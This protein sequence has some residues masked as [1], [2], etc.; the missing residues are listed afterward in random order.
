MTTKEPAGQF[1][2]KRRSARAQS[3]PGPGDAR[4][5]ADLPQAVAGRSGDGQTSKTEAGNPGAAAAASSDEPDQVV[6][7]IERT[8]EQLGETVE[9]L[10]AK[11]D[12]AAMAKGKIGQASAHAAE[13]AS[14]ARQQAAVHAARVRAQLSDR[15]AGPWQKAQA[16]SGPIRDQARSGTAAAAA[17]VSKAV[18]DPVRRA[19]VKAAA[20]ARERRLPLVM[21]AIVAVLAWRAIAGLRRR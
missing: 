1:T 20:T 16:A 9:A 8:R 15:T 19:A 7:D 17:Q 3:A 14:H 11:V 2:D 12:V 21:A 18:P 13:M 4:E 10:V 5:S 6:L